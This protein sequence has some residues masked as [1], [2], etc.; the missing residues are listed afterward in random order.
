MFECFIIASVAVLRPEEEIWTISIYHHPI[1]TSQPALCIVVRYRC[2]GIACARHSGN[3][4]LTAVI[5]NAS[6]AGCDCGAQAR[7]IIHTHAHHSAA[8]FLTLGSQAQQPSIKTK[9]PTQMGCNTH[10]P[11]P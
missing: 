6:I 10:V 7:H 3:Q 5:R 11:A 8:T 1:A 9:K 4:F 2:L